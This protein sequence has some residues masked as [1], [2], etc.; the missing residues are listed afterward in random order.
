MGDKE[1][2]LGDLLKNFA[3]ATEKQNKEEEKA[4]IKIQANFRGY[5]T[6]KDLERERQLSLEN[7]ELQAKLNEAT[8]NVDRLKGKREE[9]TVL[10]QSIIRANIKNVPKI[11]TKK[12]SER[13]KAKQIEIQKREYRENSSSNN[14]EI[15]ERE[16]TDNSEIEERADAN[17]FEIAE[18]ED[19]DYGENSDK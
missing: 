10:I 5:R 6:R 13:Q 16:D 3:N 9:N 14:S 1:Q 7:R 19:D 4:A 18:N 17:N 12:A 8:Q 2:Q 15:E 11:N